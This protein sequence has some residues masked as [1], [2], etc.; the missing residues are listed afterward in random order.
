MMCCTV[1]GEAAGTAAAVSLR[2]DRTTGG[3][4]VEEVQKALEHRGVRIR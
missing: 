2:S 4:S 1:T 3:V